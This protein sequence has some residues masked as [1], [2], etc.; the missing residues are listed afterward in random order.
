MLSMPRRNTRSPPPQE[1][2]KVLM[3]GL[4][5][6]LIFTKT[7]LVRER[8][9]TLL[10]PMSLISNDPHVDQSHIIASLTLCI[11]ILHHRILGGLIF[12]DS[13]QRSCSLWCSDCRYRG[14]GSCCSKH[15][16]NCWQISAMIA[17]AV[18]MSCVTKPA[19]LSIVRKADPT[20]LVAT[21]GT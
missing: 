9:I 6:A 12:A 11:S 19:Y 16:G 4:I 15:S 8:A 13:R 3:G 10:K 5:E 14:V 18:A 2:K 17:A 20:V 7:T 21:L 1:V